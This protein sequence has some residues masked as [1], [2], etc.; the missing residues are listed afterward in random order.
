MKLY[1]K[2]L[3]VTLLLLSLFS[4]DVDREISPKFEN[5]I[6]EFSY[7]KGNLSGIY[8]EKNLSLYGNRDIHSYWDLGNGYILRDY[9]YFGINDWQSPYENY[10][11]DI[12]AFKMFF[13]TRTK[14]NLV[15]RI[16][17]KFR[18]RDA[19]IY[20]NCV[21]FSFIHQNIPYELV[22]QATDSIEYL[23][24]KDT[25][26]DG[27]TY[28]LTHVKFDKLIFKDY[29]DEEIEFENLELRQVLVK[30]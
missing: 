27:Y 26:I 11:D 22:R 17:N 28:E 12:S 1:Y 8:I 2:F 18:I 25:I 30:R 9:N 10:F 6:R 19:D 15:D 29:S 21:E 24:I 3:A 5:K 20:D 16:G 23:D 13:G 4:C 14:E 7:V